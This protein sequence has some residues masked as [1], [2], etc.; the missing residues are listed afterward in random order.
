M[1]D[2]FFALLFDSGII[3]VP[4]ISDLYCAKPV[5]VYNQKME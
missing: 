1:W 4:C 5:Y 2:P 3:F